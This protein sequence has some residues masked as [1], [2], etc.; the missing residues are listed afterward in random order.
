MLESFRR[1]VNGWISRTTR[2]SAIQFVMFSAYMLEIAMS[3]MSIILENQP[4]RVSNGLLTIGFSL[5]ALICLF[6]GRLRTERAFVIGLLVL[7]ILDTTVFAVLKFD[8]GPI[9]TEIVM[10]HLLQILFFARRLCSAIPKKV[11]E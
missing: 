6:T 5:A 10:N 1:F 4:L 8:G 9:S 3:I 2:E 11:E 7:L